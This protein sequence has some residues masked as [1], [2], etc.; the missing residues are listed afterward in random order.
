MG[1]MIH[2]LDILSPDAKR[3]YFVYLLDYG[4]QEPLSDVLRK[5]FSNMAEWASRN[6]SAVIIGVGDIG[7]FDTEVLSWHKING[8][9]A[10]DLLPAILVTRTNPHTFKALVNRVPNGSDFSFIIIPLKKLCKNETDVVTLI[11]NLFQD[12]ESKKDLSQFKIQKELK[13]GL[14]K[15]IV[16]SVI[17]EPNISG[18]GFSFNKLKNFLK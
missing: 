8:E 6:E 16:K 4:W 7:H 1:L 13:P 9:E 17:L 12:I 15:A 5:N 3:D 14:G 10:Q 18:I 11:K 2:S